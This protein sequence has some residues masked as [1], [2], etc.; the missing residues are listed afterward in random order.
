MKGVN[1]LTKLKKFKQLS[2]K[3]KIVKP[4]TIKKELPPTP[5]KKDTD[6]SNKDKKPKKINLGADDIKK[7]IA[8]ISEE[9]PKYQGPENHK[10]RK[11]LYYKLSKLKK[12]LEHP[13]TLCS[14]TATKL[15]KAKKDKEQ[16]IQKKLD[17]GQEQRRLLKKQCLNCK[18]KGHEAKDCPEIDLM[19]KDGIDH[20]T[21]MCYNCGRTN[22]LLKDCRRKRRDTLEFA[23]CFV[24]KESGHIAR[25]CPQNE[26]GLYV[27]GGGCFICES[28]R[29]TAKECPNNPLNKKKEGKFK[30]TSE[31]LK[32]LNEN[33]N[34]DE[35]QK[36]GGGEELEP[37]FDEEEG[38][39]EIE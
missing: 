23:V 2:T 27:H 14:N 32:E 16:R 20:S 24:C 17:K 29:H 11:R 35:D 22:H 25:D 37:E 9:M 39:E 19:P 38:E 15:K 1:S 4:L 7:K 13:N 31:V 6:Q 26:K 18:K 33:N 21:A 12:A 34:S 8:K 10:I 36:Q 5:Q 28:V 3:K 30:K